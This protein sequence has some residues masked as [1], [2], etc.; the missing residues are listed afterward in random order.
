MNLFK[1]CAL[2]YLLTGLILLMAGCS[3]SPSNSSSNDQNPGNGDD[4]EMNDEDN[5]MNEDREPAPD[6]TYTSLSGNEYT[7]SE[8]EGKVVYLFFFGAS[9]PHCRDNGPA[10]QTT[11]YGPY[12]S[13]QNFVALGLDTWNESASNVEAFKEVTG[14]TYPLLL[15]AKESLVDYYGDAS[16]YD[17]SVVVDA[18]GN[19]AYKG[20]E[21]VNEDAEEVADVIGRELGNITQ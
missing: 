13:N 21:W 7:L 4:M 18:N 3:S 19:I 9:C 10:T 6:F 2:L 11:I 1:R 20:T 14:I 12:Q 17:R 8:L 5:E 15:N 16:K